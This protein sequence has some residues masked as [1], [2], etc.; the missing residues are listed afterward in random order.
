MIPI[1]EV[2]I[3]YRIDA[4]INTDIHLNS[5][6]KLLTLILMTDIDKDIDKDIDLSNIDVFRISISR[7]NSLSCYLPQSIS[8]SICTI[9]TTTASTG[10]HHYYFYS[11]ISIFYQCSYQYQNTRQYQLSVSKHVN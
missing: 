11:F 3:D 6:F 1:V 8:N 5:I 10:Y 7:G 4:N 9:I 2:T